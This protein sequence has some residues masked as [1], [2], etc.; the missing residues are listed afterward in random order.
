M[1]LAG[2]NEAGTVGR[3]TGG[4]AEKALV[5][6]TTTVLPLNTEPSYILTHHRREGQLYIHIRLLLKGVYIYFI[7][8]KLLLIARQKVC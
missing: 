2:T 1:I 6:S 4:S 5:P 8:Y 3:K 7:I